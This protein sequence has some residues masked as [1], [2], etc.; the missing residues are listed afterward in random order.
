MLQTDRGGEFTA[1]T[2]GEYCAEKG[3]QRQLMPPYSPQENS[4]I[5]HRN[6]TVMAMVRCMLK[7][8]AVPCTFWGEVVSTAV[9]IL[10]R[11]P[12]KAL[13]N[14]PPYE[15]WHGEKPVVQFMRM[16]GCCRCLAAKPA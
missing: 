15:A 4:V 12:T 11:S 16:F 3:L 1:I 10:N 5:E 2:F 14:K 13:K 6:Q 7:A 9:F 8:R